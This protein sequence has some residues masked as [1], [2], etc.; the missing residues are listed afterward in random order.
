MSLF[1][2]ISQSQRLKMC[3]A[4]I[5]RNITTQ[6]AF[7]VYLRKLEELLVEQK[8][9]TSEQLK[10]VQLSTAEY[11]KKMYSTPPQVEVAKPKIELVK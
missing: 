3:E 1:S 5:M 10:A 2:N 7:D 4:A 6:V 8:L 11:L 9:I